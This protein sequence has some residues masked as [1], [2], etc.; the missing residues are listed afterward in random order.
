MLR[1]TGLLASNREV[2]S[3]E[4]VMIRFC[5]L[6]YMA[7]AQS[8]A[9]DSRYAPSEVLFSLRPGV[10]KIATTVLVEQWPSRYGPIV[11]EALFRTD[12]GASAKRVGGAKLD[13]W[14]RLRAGSA[15]DPLRMSAELARMP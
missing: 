4:A 13:R 9:A 15:F 5:L 1:G 3:I 6:V 10:G 2:R 7:Y 12:P 8:V 11:I 14:Y